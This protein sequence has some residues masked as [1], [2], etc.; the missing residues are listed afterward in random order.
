MIQFIFVSISNSIYLFIAFY[1]TIC[2]EIYMNS[3]IYCKQT[4]QFTFIVV[5]FITQSM[6]FFVSINKAT[7]IYVL[8]LS[9]SQKLHARHSE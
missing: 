1:S 2:L 9:H 8:I 5:A 4:I 6:F 3:S 7:I